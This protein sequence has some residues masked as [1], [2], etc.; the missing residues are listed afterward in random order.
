MPRDSNGVYT[1]PAGN[2]VISGTVITSTW[3]NDT[4]PDL[5]NEIT[6]SLS[7]QGEGGMLAA[8]RNVNGTEA[9]P[10]I[11]FTNSVGSGLHLNTVG[12]SEV[13][14]SVDGT[15]AMRWTTTG[16]DVWD[17]SQWKAFGNDFFGA[18][19]DLVDTDAALIVSTTGNPTVE[20]HLEIGPSV[21]QS[22]DS[23]S[24]TSELNLNTLGGNV[25]YGGGTS[26]I[27]T[28]NVGA[29]ITA[30]IDTSGM[31]LNR[32]TTEQLRFTNGLTSEAQIY[33]DAG[34][35]FVIN[36]SVVGMTGLWRGAPTGGGANTMILADPDAEVR[37][38]YDG[39]E[40]LYTASGGAIEARSDGSGTEGVSYQL[41]TSTGAA[42]GFTG[43]IDGNNS[44]R[45]RNEIVG[46]SVILEGSNGGTNNT[47]LSGAPGGAVNLLFANVSTCRTVSSAS[48]GLE[49]NNQLTGGPS[50][51]R[52][53]TESDIGIS[54]T[55]PAVAGYV[56]GPYTYM[57]LDGNAT[58]R[59]IAPVGVAEGIWAS[60]GPSGSGAALIWTAMDA[61][62]DSTVAVIVSIQ[63]GMTINPSTQSD[64]T[65]YARSEDVTTAANFQTE[66]MRWSLSADAGGGVVGE[67]TQMATI[68]VE[69]GQFNRFDILWTDEGAANSDI[70]LVLKGFI[71]GV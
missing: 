44:L 34:F 53:L 54:A 43:F 26:S 62:P 50:F 60:V 40:R 49:V 39:V 7:R 20:Q 22:K 70:T 66:L 59:S 9:N 56:G 23:S 28:F 47:L 13:W 69:A 25:F 15:R 8:L 3:A 14:M 58:S 5:G 48:G 45:L 1:L 29:N 55:P 27:H 67:Q 11:T 64:L 68:P 6:N 31:R 57:H 10:S 17:G 63:T 18:D 71:A 35:S 2:P 36:Q 38:Y 37:L 24:S 51:E 61:L 19:P 41:K 16:V 65:I 33:S 32:T 46:G 52:V 12:P 30:S 42:K 4:M 21:I